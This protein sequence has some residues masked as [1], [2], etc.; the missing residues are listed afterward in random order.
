MIPNNLIDTKLAGLSEQERQQ[1]LKILKDF[2][3]GSSK[4]LN[5][6]LYKDYEEIP[7]DIH[8]FLHD[9]KYLGKGLT[10]EEGRFTLFPYWENFLKEIYPDPLKPAIYNTVGLTGGIGLGKST[11]AVIIGLYELYRMLCLR[12]PYIYYGLQPIDLITFAVMNI[13]LDA[14]K[15]VAW[16]K[17]QN[18]I[19]SSSWFMDRGTLTKS[20]VPEWKPPKGI[21]LIAGSQTRHIIGRAVYWCLDGDTV[22]KT[23]DGEFKIKDLEDK[24]I[25]VYNLS[26]DGDVLLSDLCTVK[27]TGR[28]SEAYDIELE[29]GSIMRCTPNHRF[30]LKDGTYKEAK[31]LTLDDELM[32]F[33]F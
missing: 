25:R 6:L 15:S 19:Q 30:M 27:M 26:S 5:E 10:D 8:T 31:D 1:A 29:D 23:S 20:D 9:P 24:P 28:F 32:D 21:E 33:A 7:V 18:L 4:S 2:Y 16:D 17:M 3:A 22:I 13:T 11:E 12:D 14:A